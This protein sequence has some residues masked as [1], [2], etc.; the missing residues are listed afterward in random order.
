MLIDPPEMRWGFGLPVKEI[1]MPYEQIKHHYFLDL[2]AD[3]C[4]ESTELYAALADMIWFRDVH[5]LRRALQIR[6]PRLLLED[7]F[8]ITDTTA[9]SDPLCSFRWVDRREGASAH[10]QT[11]TQTDESRSRSSLCSASR[12][13][14]SGTKKSRAHAR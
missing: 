3:M 12:F 8:V 9:D 5:I 1:K 11:A 14:S 2:W 10:F 13:T 4:T 6:H 7:V